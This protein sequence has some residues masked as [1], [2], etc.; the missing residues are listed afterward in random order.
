MNRSAILCA[1]IGIFALFSVGVQ[2]PLAADG[3]EEVKRLEQS[4]RRA[5][6]AGDAASYGRILAGDYSI[7]TSAGDILTWDQDVARVKAGEF[8]FRK[9]EISDVAVRRYGKTVIVT[10]KATQSATL[11]EKDLSGEFR[12]TRV[13]IKRKGG[14]KAVSAQYT[15]IAASLR[16]S[17]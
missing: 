14:W 3:T 2:K 8:R 10:G 11:G 4:L 5:L 16:S 12:F 9:L 7:T 17:Q 13:W 15:R 6:L 1:A